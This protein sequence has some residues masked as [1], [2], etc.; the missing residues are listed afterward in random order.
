MQE[1]IECAF[2]RGIEIIF[3]DGIELTRICFIAG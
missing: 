1:E 3:F 2:G